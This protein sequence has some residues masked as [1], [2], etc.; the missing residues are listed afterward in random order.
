M[1][2]RALHHGFF[3][4]GMAAALGIL[5][6]PWL[7]GGRSTGGSFGGGL[8][9]ALAP[10]ISMV[11]LA[12]IA[13]FASLVAALAAAFASEPLQAKRPSW[14]PVLLVPATGTVNVLLLIAMGTIG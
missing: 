12:I 1:I 5:L 4:I 10:I 2:A 14:L 7:M 3:W 13:L 6:L 8:G 9:S 11:A